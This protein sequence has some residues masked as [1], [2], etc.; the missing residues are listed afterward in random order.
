MC[1]VNFTY[2]KDSYI[3]VFNI[4]KC[5]ICEYERIKPIQ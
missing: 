3:D 1:Q 5:N 2:I 4:E